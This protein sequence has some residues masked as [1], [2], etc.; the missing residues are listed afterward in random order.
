MDGQPRGEALL[1]EMREQTQAALQDIR[2]LVDGLRPPA[3]DEL[4]LACALR[5]H[6]AQYAHSGLTVLVEA[7]ERLPA[8]PAAVEVAAYRIALEAVTNAVRHA[9]A[10][11]CRVCLR[12][13]GD[14]SLE[15]SDDGRGLTAADLIGMGLT[16]MRERAA[17]L[18]GAC[19]IDGRP[20]QG[21]RVRVRLPLPKE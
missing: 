11:T 1:L 6:A 19:A 5:E 8:L 18:G 2:R 20:G 16:S 14:L 15:I 7:P 3:L 4:G 17:E 10:R 21:T 13:D 9:E 12:A